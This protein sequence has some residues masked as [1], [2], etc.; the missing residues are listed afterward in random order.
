MLNNDVI[1]YT[2]YVR[3]SVFFTFYCSLNFF[4]FLLCTSVTILIINK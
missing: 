1:S 3:L 2:N 4:L